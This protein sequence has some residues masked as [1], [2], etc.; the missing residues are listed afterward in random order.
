MCTHDNHLPRELL[1]CHGHVDVCWQALVHAASTRSATLCPAIIDCVGVC[2]VAFGMCRDSTVDSDLCSS[3]E[4]G[5]P[6]LGEAPA[7]RTPALA[8]LLLSFEKKI[9][10]SKKEPPHIRDGA[11]WNSALQQRC[12]VGWLSRAHLKK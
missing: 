11:S 1:L 3:L 12:S 6:V 10:K 7:V 4:A 8:R 5:Q 9:R 2:G